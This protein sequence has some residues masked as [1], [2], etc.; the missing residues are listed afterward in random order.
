MGRLSDTGGGA[1]RGVLNRLLVSMVLGLAAAGCIP[2]SPSPSAWTQ[3][4][5]QSLEDS[6]GALASAHLVLREEQRGHLLGKSGIVMLVDAEEAT[7]RT[8]QTFSAL[9]PPK[10]LARENKEVTRALTAAAD[11]VATARRT[12][13]DEDASSYHDLSRRLLDERDRLNRLAGELK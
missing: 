10:D 11:L 9:Q 1:A 12:R 5:T 13:V 4:A 2:D 6:A 3:K 7:G 8:S